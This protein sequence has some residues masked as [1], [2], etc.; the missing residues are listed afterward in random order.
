MLFKLFTSA[1][2]VRGRQAGARTA[3]HRLAATQHALLQRLGEAPG[4]LTETAF[5]KLDHRFGKCQLAV[6]LDNVLG[7]KAAGDHEQSQIANRFDRPRTEFTQPLTR[8]RP[9]GHPAEAE[10]PQGFVVTGLRSMSGTWMD[11]LWLVC[12]EVQRER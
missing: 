9:G 10:C 7:R 12:S 3:A 1:G 11:H 5:K 2:K 4:R 8:P 6:P